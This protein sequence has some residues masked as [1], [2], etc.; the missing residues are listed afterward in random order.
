MLQ[1][2]IDNEI[3]I[4]GSIIDKVKALNLWDLQR[5]YPCTISEDGYS[6]S[7]TT[8]LD[9]AIR[10]RLPKLVSLL[11]NRGLNLNRIETEDN[12]NSDQL[13]L[14]QRCIF[15]DAVD[16]A[17]IVI[18]EGALYICNKLSISMPNA[19]SSIVNYK[20]PISFLSPLEYAATVNFNLDVVCLLLSKEANTETS[21]SLHM[22][23]AASNWKYLKPLLQAGVDINVR[24]DSWQTALHT[25]ALSCSCDKTFSTLVKHGIDI[26]AVDKVGIMNNKLN[27]FKNNFFKSLYFL[28]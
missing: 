6:C 1:E 14:L 4:E 22:A 17:L 25:F 20:N 15:M 18:E 12:S 2:V 11:I 8:F 3:D 28:M 26:D 5:I 21:I 16:I 24:N 23:V 13:T 9:L 27:I 10:R 19:V 7:L